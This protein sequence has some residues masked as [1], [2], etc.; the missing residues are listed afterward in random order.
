ME[1][2]RI[3]KQLWFFFFGVFIIVVIFGLNIIYFAE[4]DSDTRTGLYMT[5]CGGIVLV[6]MAFQGYRRE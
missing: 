4:H 3:W 1:S 6:V 2:A 5:I